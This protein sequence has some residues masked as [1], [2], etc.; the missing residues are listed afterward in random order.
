MTIHFWDKSLFVRASDGEEIASASQVT[1]IVPKM[2]NKTLSL[3]A[4]EIATI[5]SSTGSSSLVIAGI[6]SYFGNFSASHLLS[7]VRNLSFISHFM[8]MQLVYPP[9]S[10]AFY[11]ILFNFLTFDILPTDNIYVNVFGWENVPYSDNADAI[12]Y[13]SRFLIENSGSITIFILL[14]IL[15]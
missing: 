10:V 12:G 11:A 6:L 1:K 9:L 13:P 15:Q 4:E 8:M 5:M 7:E 14:L 3:V 2:S